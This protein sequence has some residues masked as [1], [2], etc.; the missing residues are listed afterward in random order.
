MADPWE[1]Y[2]MTPGGQEGDATGP[3]SKY[4]PSKPGIVERAKNWLTGANREENIGGPLSIEL[5]MTS[6]QSAQ[7]TALL[8]TTMSPD[9]LKSG[10]QKIEPDV[11]FR[12][13]SF[14]NLVALWPRKDERGQVTGYQQF[15]P[16]PTGLDT[17]DVMRASGAVAAATPVGRVLR[18]VG[19]PT[20]GLTG[21]ATIGATEAALIEGASS[22]LSDA[23]Y[24]YSDILYGAGGGVA[25]DALAR[26]V[27]SLVAAARSVGP[28]SV[29]DAS[30]NLLP[31]Y[32]DLVRKAGLD[33]NQV[34]AAVV[35]DITNLARAGAEP[36]Q[37]AVA[38]MSRGLPTPV[39]M[40]QGQL[41]GSGR[42]QLLEDTLSKG[43]FGDLA[44]API[45][46]Q[47]A[48]QQAALT[49][50]LDQIL[51]SL[52]PGAAPI[53]RGEGGA[54]AQEVLSASRTAE[55]SKADELYT[56]ARQTSAVVEQDSALSI[57][58]SMRSAYGTGYSP[59]TAPTMFKLLDEF[60]TIAL[61]GRTPSGTVAPGDIRTMMEWRQKV[62]NLRKGAPTVDAAAAGEVLEQF[63]AKVKDAIDQAMLSGDPAAVAKWSEAISNYAEFASKWKSKG[64]ILNL[65]TERAG[66]DGE[67]VFKVAPSQAADVVFT[68]TAS[69]LASK[70]GLP[71]D[72]ITLQR[73]L[74]K[75]QWDAMRQEAFIRLMDTSRGGMRGG[76]TQ[77][78][79]VN[80]KKAWENLRE[81]NPGVVN[82]LFT[83]DEQN[84]IQQ[85]ADV[86]A[87]ATNT[88]ANTSNTAAAA[89][90]LIQTI[91]ASLGGKGPVQFAMRLPIANALRNAYGGALATM[92]ASGRVPAGATPLTTGA[93]G[94]GAA[95]A[96]TEE[97]RRQ[98]N[99]IPPVVGGVYN[100]MMGLLGE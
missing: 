66:R 60:D 85:F 95:A 98:I 18:A 29:I 46:A 53:T 78:S 15:Y 40:T 54:R 67:V 1:K 86:S 6:R 38:A 17:S 52:R 16:N 26:T 12:E 27:Q 74:P 42:Q 35:A 44:A 61:G 9:R 21:A 50:N 22:A 65:L 39:P 76:E 58:D 96:N 25:G 32:A 49:Q 68:A 10:I 3:W 92:A 56:Q 20:A 7:M 30:G 82:G 89:S 70:T 100:R 23:P 41:T 91:A 71:R 84:L 75:D 97:G 37:A 99:A 47:R 19:L 4:A 36:S 63:D 5:P 87:R 57:A 69:G 24:Q 34:S 33:P 13:D 48:R 93:A 14:G 73:N 80:F 51:E 2:Q 45:V 11:Q 55:R 81:K 59:S 43:G 72:L 94:A 8:A 90:G 83:K 28:Q 88:L 62:S 79:G 77:V 64:G 31:Q